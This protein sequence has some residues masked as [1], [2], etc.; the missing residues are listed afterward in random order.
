M[1]D[2][3]GVKKLPTG[4]RGG[5]IAGVAPV[6]RPDRQSRSAGGEVASDSKIA[7]GANVSSPLSGAGDMTEPAFVRK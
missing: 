5:G 3:T 6:S 1:R 4:R 7:S 2:V